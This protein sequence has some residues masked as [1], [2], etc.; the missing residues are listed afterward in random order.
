VEAAFSFETNKLAT[1]SEWKAF[2]TLYF[3][4]GLLS[5]VLP[6]AGAWLYSNAIFVLFSYAV[7]VM[8]PT[9]FARLTRREKPKSLQIARIIDCF[10][11][12][13]P[14]SLNSVIRQVFDRGDRI[15]ISFL[16]GAAAAG[17]Y[18]L[19]AD[20]IRRPI[21]TLG[22]ALQAALLPRLSRDFSQDKSRFSTSWNENGRLVIWICVLT[23]VA[24]VTS[25][26]IVF[27][28]S[29][30]GKYPDYILLIAVSVSVSAT[31]EA[32]D[33]YHASFGLVASRDMKLMPL[34]YVCAAVAF[35]AF[36]ALAWATSNLML[37]ALG[38]VAAN[39]IGLSG[40]LI[41][42][43]RKVPVPI[44]YLNFGSAITYFVL[45]IAVWLELN[46][47]L[48]VWTAGCLALCLIV[49][50]AGLAYFVAFRRT[51]SAA[52][53]RRPRVTATRKE[54]L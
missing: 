25:I 8:L 52:L 2:A 14:L 28:K 48:P 29:M 16:F 36:C 1:R 49:V 47:G 23:A 21:Q 39:V 3:G 10:R 17:V 38:V 22:G 13:F 37:V 41:L 31:L 12:Y 32:L 19:A 54:T 30:H 7:G 35:L 15:A 11:T 43:R 5:F 9:A 44:D 6:V 53:N 4:R 46:D 24:A 40:V 27:I 50:G 20:V 33:T 51:V 45:S 18:S 42:S 26:D 34:V